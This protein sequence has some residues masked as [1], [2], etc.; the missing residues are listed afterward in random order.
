MKRRGDLNTDELLDQPPG[1]RK[2]VT[3][4]HFTGSIIAEAPAQ[5]HRTHIEPQ[6]PRSPLARRHNSDSDAA[7]NHIET[8]VRRLR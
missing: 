5:P 4:L 7:F 2:V 8:T 1:D 6:L 3:G